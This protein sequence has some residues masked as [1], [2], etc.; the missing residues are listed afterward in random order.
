MADRFHS[1]VPLYF[2]CAWPSMTIRAR[3]P[4]APKTVRRKGAATQAS[5][6]GFLWGKLHAAPAADVATL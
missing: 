3:T 1:L 2:I 6:L 5:T 4:A